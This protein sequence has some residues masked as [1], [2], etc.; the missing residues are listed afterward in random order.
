MLSQ[1]SSRQRHPRASL[2]GRLNNSDLLQALTKSAIKYSVYRLLS[3]RSSSVKATSIPGQEPRSH[4]MPSKRHSNN[5]YPRSQTSHDRDP[6]HELI[7]HLV[8][9]AA[10]LA[11]RHLLKKRPK[12]PAKA[13]EHQRGRPRERKGTNIPPVIVTPPSPDEQDRGLRPHRRR[14]RH[15]LD[16]ISRKELTTALD[17]L[18]AELERMTANIRDLAGKRRP[19]RHRDGR[20]DVFEGL[21]YEV[22]RL[23]GRLEALRMGVNNVRNLGVGV[24]GRRRGDGGGGG[25][26]GSWER[27]R[28]DGGAGGRKRVRVKEEEGRGR[29]RTR[30]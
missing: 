29:G 15:T 17:A 10:A 22:G 11:A 26:R 4:S 25:R 30:D 23:E 20:C 13:E 12:S 1:S 7:S 6:T 3:R 5:H 28:P 24:E 19:H 21:R 27:L 9:G 8:R 16:E 18:S 2:S 14:R